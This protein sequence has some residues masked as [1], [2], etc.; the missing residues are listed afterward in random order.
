MASFGYFYKLVRAYCTDWV[1]SSSY[2][3]RSYFVLKVCSADLLAT[4]VSMFYSSVTAFYCLISL[5]TSNLCDIKDVIKVCKGMS[6]SSYIILL[7]RL[8]NKKSK[9]LLVIASLSILLFCCNYLV[10]S[11]DIAQSFNIFYTS[12]TF[13]NLQTFSSSIEACL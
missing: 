6:R 12:S 5:C 2:S 13:T 3:L 1:A 8:K 4:D 7:V 10:T 11:S 9:M